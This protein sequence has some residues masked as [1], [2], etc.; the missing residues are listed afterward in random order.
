MLHAPEASQ[1]S[2]KFQTLL[3]PANPTTNSDLDPVY[4]VERGTYGKEVEIKCIPCILQIVH[5]RMLKILGFGIVDVGDAILYFEDTFN[6]QEPAP[7]LRPIPETIFFIDSQGNEWV[8]I[9]KD[10]G[11]L[12][13]FL[14]M[15]LGNQAIAAVVPCNLKKG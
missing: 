3:L 1:V 11:Q 6:L 5:E 10:A 12:K 14:A 13:R 9:L 7:G 15:E 8:P 4:K 2:L